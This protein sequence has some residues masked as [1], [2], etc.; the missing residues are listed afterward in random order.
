[1]CPG[2]LQ[3]PPGWQLTGSCSALEYFPSGRFLQRERIRQGGGLRISF[4]PPNL[5]RPPV[6][7]S[8]PPTGYYRVTRLRN[9]TGPGGTGTVGWGHHPPTHF[10]TLHFLQYFAFNC[11]S[12]RYPAVRPQHV[13]TISTG[14]PPFWGGV[15][16]IPSATASQ[17]H[18]PNVPKISTG[19]SPICFWRFCGSVGDRI[20]ASP[21]KST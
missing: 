21:P 14:L 4:T 1:M 5:L 10:K 2:V 20:A 6:I 16:S 3:S 18:H 8:D 13:P 12:L 9:R 17:R 15:F 19:P 7:G 11:D